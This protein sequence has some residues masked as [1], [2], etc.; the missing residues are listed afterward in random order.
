MPPEGAPDAAARPASRTG[1]DAVIAQLAQAVA[2]GLGPGGESPDPELTARMLSA[3]AD[4]A[5]RLLLTDPGRYPVQRLIAHAE[6]VL[7][8]LG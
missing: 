7:D 2:P 3:I 5:A 1:R 8:Q 4:E 6:W